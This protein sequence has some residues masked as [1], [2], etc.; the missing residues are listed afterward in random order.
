MLIPQLQASAQSLVPLV[1]QAK[2]VGTGWYAPHSAHGEKV[3]TSTATTVSSAPSPDSREASRKPL[4]AGHRRGALWAEVR[5]P[6]PG[7]GHSWQ[8]NILHSWRATEAHDRNDRYV[9]AGRPLLRIPVHWW[10]QR[11]SDLRN[12]EFI[13]ATSPLSPQM[14]FVP[15]AWRKVACSPYSSHWFVT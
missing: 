1:V 2:L 11:A 9:A 12:P 3:Q 6:W 15:E 14:T 5:T 7:T 13:P 4:W 8:K 10:R